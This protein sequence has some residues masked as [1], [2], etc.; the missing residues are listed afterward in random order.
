VIQFKS[1]LDILIW[2]KCVIVAAIIPL[3]F[4]VAFFFF[5]WGVFQFMIATTAEKRKEGRQRIWWGL[6]ALFVMVSVWGIIKILSDTVGTGSAVP[7]LQTDYL[8]PGDQHAGN[9]PAP[10]GGTVHQNA[11]P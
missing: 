3:I 1:A 10:A 8:N 7:F 2:L 4:A 6:I 5:L 11:A 9:S